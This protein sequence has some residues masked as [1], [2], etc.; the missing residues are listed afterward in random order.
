MSEQREAALVVADHSHLLVRV[1][2]YDLAI[3]IESIISVHEAPALF[4]VPCAQPGIA[5]AVQFQGFAV[6][7]FD[8]R[9]SL[10][11]TPR[12]VAPR[13]RLVLLDVG[14]RLM[15]LIVDEVKEF[16]SLQRITDEG[17]HALFGDSPVNAK[18][19]AGIA[20]ADD[21]CAIIDPAGLLQPDIWDAEIVDDVYAQQLS[22]T[23]PLAIRTAALAQIPAAPQ[24][25]GVEAAIF[26]LAGQRF[27]VA[28][29][30]IVEF[31]SGASHAPIPVRSA[32]PVSLVNRRGEGIMLFDPR[33][34]L[35]LPPAPLPARVDGI[36]LA[37]DK[38]P[39]ALPVDS[40]E[41]LGLL[42]RADSSLA[43]GR[44]CLSVHPSPP[45]AVVL[46]DVP[47]FL[48]HAQSAFS[49]RP[50]PAGAAA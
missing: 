11:L 48:H 2:R 1:D 24:A 35:G 25:I 29:P 46:L 33:P 6:P 14:I 22:P 49:S 41:G 30:N 45:G 36:I 44:F 7:V 19:I 39:T 32:I 3:P 15:G 26:R 12:A 4:P 34:I 47:A 37:N 28:L 38:A 23:D 5:G 13:D 27:G 17:P 50:S 21:L 8:L 42:P 10:R 16:V 31:F 9:R 43:P 40:L 20:C 18:I